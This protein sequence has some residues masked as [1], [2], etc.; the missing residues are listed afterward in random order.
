M[1]TATKDITVLKNENDQILGVCLG[2]DFT[3]EH[4]MGF[5][6]FSR[7]MGIGER[8]N[9]HEGKQMLKEA[10]F[11]RGL[12]GATKLPSVGIESRMVTEIP[13]SMLLLK[14]FGN[15]TKTL[16]AETRL[17]FSSNPE[18]FADRNSKVILHYVP[19]R[20]YSRDDKLP[21]M[22]AAWRDGRFIVR[23]FSD[24]DRDALRLVYK[25]MMTG[26]L[27]FGAAANINPIGNSGPALVIA[28]RLS[29]ET[30]TN[31]LKADVDHYKLLKAADDSGIAK[32]L[33]K[34]G[35]RYF[36]LSPRWK[37]DNFKDRDT[38]FN[39]V[40]WLNP[41]QQSSYTTGYFTVE[42]LEAWAKDE[43]PVVKQAAA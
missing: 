37:A 13:E 34:A 38:R 35:K 29:S 16:D 43:G 27:A 26:D 11:K 15:T 8:A 33:E 2:W 10:G 28:S 14:E 32:T 7:L 30:K 5:K 40:F 17:V 21:K 19:H 20:K 25:A 42:E 23:A 4:E 6:R 3:A 12:F 31:V 39:V 18:E 22:K 36:A 41:M 1:K 9:S 24:E